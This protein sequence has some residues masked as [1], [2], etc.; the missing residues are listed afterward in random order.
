MILRSAAAKLLRSFPHLVHRAAG[1]FCREAL[2][3]TP[4]RF[5]P[6][7][8]FRRPDA[9]RRVLVIRLDAIGDFL[10]STPALRALRNRWPEADLRVLVQPGVAA[11]ARDLEWIDGV[12]TLPCDFLMR[13]AGWVSGAARWV[14]VLWRLRRARVDL[15][16]DFTGLFHSAAAAWATGAPVRMGFRRR[17]ALGCFQTEGFGRFY[18]HAYPPAEGVHVSRE[19][20]LLVGVLGAEAGEGGW[21]MNVSREARRE[22]GRIFSRAGIDPVRA[23]LV[24]VHPA[25]KWPPKRWPAARFAETLDILHD[26]GWQAVVNLGPGEEDILEALRRAGRTSPA[27]LWPPVPLPVLGALLERADVFL[28]NDS[29]PMHMAAAVGTPVV[30]LF[31]PTDPERSGPKGGPAAILYERLEC[32]PCRM[33]F[34]RDRCRRGHNYCMDG[35]RPSAVAAAVESAAGESGRRRRSSEISSPSS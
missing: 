1:L 9:V 3:E 12:E 16:V 35:F 8:A 30:A 15:A 4:P 32:S 33:Y 5:P 31:G 19:L 6:P 23:P 20:N 34:T 25:G 21:E 2:W 14:S 11:L 28:G 22:A 29:G 18:T 7:D 17:L 10:M 26:R 27:L 24:F 13:G